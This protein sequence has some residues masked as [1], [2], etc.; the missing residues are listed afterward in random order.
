MYQFQIEMFKIAALWINMC[1]GSS[2]FDFSN[3][4][5]WLLIFLGKEN[6]S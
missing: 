4:N 2:E 3:A 6:I 1:F 5:C